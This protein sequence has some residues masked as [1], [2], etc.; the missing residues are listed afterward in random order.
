MGHSPK[1]LA[2]GEEYRVTEELIKPRE[3]LVSPS[4]LEVEGRYFLSELK[5]MARKAGL[6]AVGTK[7]QLCRRLIN[8]GIIT[9]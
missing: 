1:I 6:S 2:P 5:D 8:A 4:I 9:K 3:R 7:D